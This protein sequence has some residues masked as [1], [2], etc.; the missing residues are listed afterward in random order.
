MP[1]T[2]HVSNDQLL[3][4]M[5]IKVALLLN[6]EAVKITT[7]RKPGWE[8][9]ALTRYID[10]KTDRGNKRFIYSKRVCKWMAGQGLGKI[11]KSQNLPRVT[12]I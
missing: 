2:E 3:G 12:N 7:M 1:F 9:L 10:G 11:G 8:T 5:E 6:K 4:K